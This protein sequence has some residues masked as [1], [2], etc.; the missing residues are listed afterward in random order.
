MKY[1][2]VINEW[3]A[4]E[5]L[6]ELI[7]ACNNQDIDIMNVLEKVVPKIR[8]GKTSFTSTGISNLRVL[9]VRLKVYFGWLCIYQL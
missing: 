7:D 6:S 5:T 4:P 3:Q 1:P 2:P 8:D 9:E